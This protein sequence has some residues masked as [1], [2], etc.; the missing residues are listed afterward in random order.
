ML[1]VVCA[2]KTLT[3]RPTFV[4]HMDLDL[5]ILIDSDGDDTTT[6]ATTTTTTTT[7]LLP[8]TSLIKIPKKKT[9]IVTMMTN[10]H[11]PPVWN[12]VHGITSASSMTSITLRIYCWTL[13]E[14]ETSR[15]VFFCMWSIAFDVWLSIDS[16]D[17]SECAL[18]TLA[19]LCCATDRLLICLVLLSP[20][21]SINLCIISYDAAWLL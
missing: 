14:E 6:A 12:C 3:P 15:K 5:T 7:I 2:L 9:M 19:A 10:R 4:H 16:V 20:I 8:T 17:V 18:Y 11:Y 1:C 13:H 21:K